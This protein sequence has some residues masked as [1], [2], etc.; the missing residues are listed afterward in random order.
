MEVEFQYIQ[1]T[2]YNL[3]TSDSGFHAALPEVYTINH[4]GFK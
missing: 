3:H 2:E 4:E 1:S